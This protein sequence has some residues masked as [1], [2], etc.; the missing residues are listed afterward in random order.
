VRRKTAWFG[1]GGGPNPEALYRIGPHAEL[2]GLRAA[3]LPRVPTREDDGESPHATI[4]QAADLQVVDPSSRF[5]PGQITGTIE[6]GRP[7]G[8]RAVALAVNGT[9]VATG[10]TFSL[11][12]T[13]NVENFEVMV[14]ESAFRRGRNDARVFEIVPGTSGAALRPL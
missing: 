7:G 12:G 6:R 14:P 2:V 1:S 4:D 9:V 13:P 10:R 3:A 11:E 5:I 8:G